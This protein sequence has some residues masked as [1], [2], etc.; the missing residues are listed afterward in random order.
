MKKFISMVRITPRGKK[1]SRGQSLVEFALLLPVFLM[2]VMGVID[3]ARAFSALQV[4]TNASREGARVGILPS[5]APADVTNVV[6]NYLASGGQ[7]GCNTAGANWGTA[8]A[9][10]TSTTVTVTCNFVTL[11]GTLI[12]AW[13]GTIALTQTASMRHE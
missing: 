13:N 12:P 11:T 7:V 6:N 8:A 9:A 5:T 1:G 3:I 2:L 10:G 4:V